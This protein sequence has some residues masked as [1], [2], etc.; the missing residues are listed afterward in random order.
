MDIPFSQAYRVL[1]EEIEQE[2]IIS[3]RTQNARTVLCVSYD[4]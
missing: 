3:V 1:L 4:E 2:I